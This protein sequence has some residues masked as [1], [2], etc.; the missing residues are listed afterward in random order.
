[1][2]VT[3]PEGLRG[4]GG[5][6]QARDG[7]DPLLYIESIPFWETRGYVSIVLRNY[8]MYERN[9]GKISPS[10]A[11]LAQGLWP[12]FP[13]MTGAPAIRLQTAIAPARL[14]P[15]PPPPSDPVI[16]APAIAAASASATFGSN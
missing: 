15:L 13:G 1:M 14:R 8:W 2:A 9:G 11:A 7:G 3:R 4:S 5:G 6:T 16:L 12:K 10:R